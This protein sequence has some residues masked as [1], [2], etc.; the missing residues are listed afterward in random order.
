MNKD[1]NIAV[2]VIITAYNLEKYIGC[3]IDS[4]MNQT[5][6]NIEIILVD[7]CSIDNTWSI[8]NSYKD[9]TEIKDI[10]L[11]RNDKNMGAGYSRNR[12]L[13]LAKG[14]YL[15][16]LD[17]DDFFER[18]M[19]E[20]LYLA[21][22]QSDADIAIC[23]W[24]YFDNETGHSVKYDDTED[25]P[26][27]NFYKTFQLKDIHEFAFQ[28]IHE[29][30]WNKM[31]RRQF[32]LE[33]DIRFQCQH[34]A[35]DQFFVFASCLKAECIVHIKDCLLSYRTNIKN[36]LSA[37]ISK[38]PQCIWNA[39]KATLEY[40]DKLGQYDL[41][42]KSFNGYLI[43][44][45]LFSLQRIDETD[46]KCLFDFY[47]K[48]GFKDLRI[49]MCGAQDFYIPYFYGK[50]K[51]L[52]NIEHVEDIQEPYLREI[53]WESNKLKELFTR[54]QKDPPILW[55]AGINGVKFLEKANRYNIRLKCVIDRDKQKIG[56]VVQGYVIKGKDN[57][58]EGDMIVVL[59]P[60][61]IGMIQQEAKQQKKN[62]RLL[63]ARA[64]LC[65]D[66]EFE[67]AIFNS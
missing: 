61:H 31:F 1:N 52:I 55:G 62:I 63:D 27:L 36:Q 47:Q 42:K 2:S 59:N 12:G 20:K 33:N 15:V 49:E 26:F 10:V 25:F 30:A 66:I 23:N 53:S 17:G 44:R 9:I 56:D 14:K 29:I 11:I 60:L 21:C 50:W 37:S 8:I 18:N 51:W 24:H 19:I 41:Y 13:E 67:Q 32:I 7:D 43:N 65:F 34:N 64:Y 6:E 3:C 16:F 4:I 58:E 48:E 38:S 46:K 35:N 22:E 54:L 45:L 39:S 28:Y 40:I 57:F 5:I